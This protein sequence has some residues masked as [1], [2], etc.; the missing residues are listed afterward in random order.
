MDMRSGLPGNIS[1]I[2]REVVQSP[3]ITRE[4]ITTIRAM[5]PPGFDDSKLVVPPSLNE[6]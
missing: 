1:S 3:D 5:K 2:M 6:P 4:F